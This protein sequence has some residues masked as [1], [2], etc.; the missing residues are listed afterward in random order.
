[1][2]DPRI[3]L[4]RRVH[5]G[6][7]VLVIHAAPVVHDA[8]LELLPVAGGAARIAEEHRPTLGRRRPEIRDTS[9]RRTVR[10]DRRECSGSSDIS[11]RPA[12]RP[13]SPGSRR[14]PS[15]RCSC[16]AAA[17]P[18][19]RSSSDHSCGIEVRELAL[20]AAVQR[21][22]VEI[23]QM[24]EIVGQVG[25]HAG[26]LVDVEAVDGALAR[27]SPARPC[28]PSRSTRKIC[29]V[30]F[31]SGLEAQFAARPDP[32]AGPWESDRDLPRPACDLP[33]PAGERDVQLRKLRGARSGRRRQSACRPATS[34]AWSSSNS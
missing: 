34:A 26:L 3:L 2:I 33:P 12:S 18:S 5:A 22:H 25:H 23:V 32:S 29:V 24:L 4:E 14:C 21:G 17:R 31:D 9:R 11:C 27:W 20:A 6:H 30:P 8:A 19:R 16:R 15:H 28:A 1:M 13:A 10:P 7:D